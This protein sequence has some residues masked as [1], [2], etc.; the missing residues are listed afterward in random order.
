[1]R[2]QRLTGL[3]GSGLGVLNA[4]AGDGFISVIQVGIDIYGFVDSVGTGDKWI[5]LAPPARSRVYGFFSARSL[6]IRGLAGA[7]LSAVR[8]G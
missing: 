4:R 1:M 7:I 6:H 8:C 3:I 2:A 5:T